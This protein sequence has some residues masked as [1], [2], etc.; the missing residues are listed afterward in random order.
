MIWTTVSSLL[1]ADCI[2]L[3]HLWLQEYNQSNLVIDHL[4]MSMCGVF[5]CAI[6]RGSLLWLV[7]S[8][9]KALSVFALLHFVLQGQIC[10]LLQVSLD[11]LFLHSCPL[12]W[13][14]HLFWVFVLGGFTGLHRTVQLQLL[15]YYWLGHR[16]GLLWCWMVCLGNRDYSVVFKIACKYCIS[17]SSVD[18]DGYSIS[19]KGFLSTVVDIMVICVKFTHSSPF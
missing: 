4:V 16:L 14:G 1:F 8:F 17:D 9:G 2:E 19:S 7:V 10:L 3:L 12:Q 18:C 15:Q 13:K 11:F 6:G 5:F